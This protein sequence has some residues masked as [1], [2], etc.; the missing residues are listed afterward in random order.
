M[1]GFSSKAACGAVSHATNND[2]TK[3]SHSAKTQSMTHPTLD[4]EAFR[5]LL[6][7]R[8]MDDDLMFLNQKSIGFGLHIL[9]ASNPDNQLITTITELIKHQLPADIDCTIMLH[10]HQYINRDLQYG[11][12]PLQQKGGFFTR[13]AK[14]TLAM[15][16]NAITKSDDNQPS[17]IPL[18]DY[19]CYLFLSTHRHLDDK[20]VL[21]EC[22][23]NIESLLDHT[24]LLH[25]RVEESDFLVLMRA[26]IA[27]DLN[28]VDW[29][30]LANIKQASFNHVIPPAGIQFTLN[31][32]NIGVESLASDGSPVLSRIVNCQLQSWP[33][34]TSEQTMDLLNTTNRPELQLP[35]NYVIS[36]T[37]RKRNRSGLHPVFYNLILFTTSAR[38]SCH[39]EQAIQ[40]YLAVGITLQRT[41]STQWLCFL[42]SL[43]FFMT[44]GFYHELN[45]LGMI[46]KMS[47][48]DVIHLLPI[49]ADR[50][51]SR[52][53]L[54]LPT[55]N[56]QIAFIN[57]FDQQ[58]YPLQNFNFLMTIGPNQQHATFQY[59]HIINGL[60]L[61]EMIY[62]LD[63]DQTYT[64]LSEIVDGCI[65]DMSISTFNPFSFL[66]QTITEERQLLCDLL[67]I[68]I[69]PMQSLCATQRDYLLAILSE[70][71][72][73]TC[74]NDV[75]NCLH[76]RTRFDPQSRLSH[77]LHRDLIDRLSPYGNQGPYQALFNDNYNMN[78]SQ[79]IILDL[80]RLQHN[81]HVFTAVVI[82]MMTCLIKHFQQLDPH[83]KKRC[84]IDKSQL[85]I[86]TSDNP[87]VTRVVKQ[88]LQAATQYRSGF[89]IITNSFADT[90]K[91]QSGQTVLAGCDLKF[92]MHEANQKAYLSQFSTNLVLPQSKTKRS[93]EDIERSSYYDILIEAG[94]TR[95]F[96][97]Y[98]SML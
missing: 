27:P 3:S 59:M 82:V 84:M 34:K 30:A 13:F 86:L 77:D 55:E 97:R 90:L 87:V 93:F 7:Y 45:L 83:L 60:A 42:T 78:D 52:Q 9:P 66:T 38:E 56:Q 76:D 95:G 70:N 6:P 98:I 4:A 63:F 37:L 79:L 46:Q 47:T 28:S 20:G 41:T 12:Q 75:L 72:A 31:T 64:P 81:A 21:R 43:P 68:I 53:G 65:I 57:T 11:L 2:S 1:T 89:G 33:D 96:H 15:H 39:V 24:Q 73:M 8:A 49:V 16:L 88:Q 25:A 92:I 62:I 35:C 18:H 69:N 71:N 94:G 26:L 10:K 48:R 54:L 40:A 36:H 58:N 80:H 19:R 74:I 17:S 51:G 85:H 67:A 32:S 50:K 29:P 61:G 91:T 23:N 44:E 14:A 22:R 5:A